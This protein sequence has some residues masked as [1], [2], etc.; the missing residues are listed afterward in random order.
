[1]TALAAVATEKG[2]ELGLEYAASGHTLAEI[3]LSNGNTVRFIEVPKLETV[4]MGEIVPTGSNEVFVLDLI[5]GDFLQKYLQ[6]T[7][8][9]VSVPQKLIDISLSEQ[10]METD[11]LGPVEAEQ[12][13]LAPRTVE[14]VLG[15]KTAAMLANR[16]V[17]VELAEP[18]Y[19]DLSELGI[20]LAPSTK[21]AGQGSCNNSTGYQYFKDNHCGTIGSQGYGKSEGYCYNGMSSSIQ[22]TS[23]K[24]MR[25]TYTRHATC[26][27]GEGRVRHSRNSAGGF[28]TYFDHNS[29]PNTVETWQSKKSGWAWK[30]RANFNK[31]SGSGYVRGWVKYFKQVVQ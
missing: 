8:D 7:P 4:F 11:Y 19:M 13:V 12:S 31:L 26:G 28:F 3:Q 21:A 15:E 25:T 17:T 20:E 1:L 10:A 29:A 16:P 5:E 6:L 9:Y 18:V 24:A 22:K 14:A 27:S 30:R 2:P 23:A